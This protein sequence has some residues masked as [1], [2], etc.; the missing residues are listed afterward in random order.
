M[1]FDYQDNYERELSHRNQLRAAVSTPIVVLT[2]VG[3]LV[4]FM[5]Q[6][7]RLGFNLESVAF[8]VLVLASAAGIAV[9]A[10][11]LARAI[12]GHTYKHIE[13][14]KRLREYH[15]ELCDWHSQHGQG[16]EVGDHE[17]DEYLE[18]AYAAAA[19]HNARLNT[20]RSSFLFLAHRAMIFAAIFA[21]AAFLPFAYGL[22]KQQ[23]E[24]VLVRLVQPEEP[25]TNQE[26]EKMKDKQKS[27]P[28]PNQQQP[29][30][31]PKPKP[32]PLRDVREDHQ[33]REKK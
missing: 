27:K 18:E 32:P 19:D 14:A 30:I 7:Y 15:H 12:H 4:G 29:I 10:F 26:I 25:T 22:Q 28:T 1:P 24:P 31:P 33:P 23:Q 16:P 8:S 6:R 17:F 2:L 11:Y 21:G 13:Y 20:L 9:A 3:S 5:F